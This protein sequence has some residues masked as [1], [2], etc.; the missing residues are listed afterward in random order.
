MK[1]KEELMTL[2]TL[3]VL[4]FYKQCR[5]KKVQKNDFYKRDVIWMN[6][7][8]SLHFFPKNLNVKIFMGGKAIFFF[9]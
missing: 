7:L 2:N 3:F 8:F 5:A 9:L 1:V 6:F 4:A